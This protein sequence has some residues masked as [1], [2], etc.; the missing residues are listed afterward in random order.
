M[1]VTAWTFAKEPYKREVVRQSEPHI[2]GDKNHESQ[3][4]VTEAMWNAWDLIVNLRGLGWNWPRGLRIPSQTCHTDSVPIFLVLSLVRL[5]FYTVA[6]DVTSGA[7]RSF[8]PETFGP[9][10][11]GTIFD[12][13][14]PPV[15][16]Y[17]RASLISFLSAWTAYFV[18]EMVYQIHAIEFTL[19]FR[20]R[21]SQWPPLFDAPWMATSI[22]NF[23]GRRWH[24]LFRDCFVAVGSRP[25][26]RYLGRVGGVMGAF[27]VSGILH[28]LGLRGMGRG[29]DSLVVIGFFLM[30]GVGLALEYAWKKGTG[31]YVG[32]F[33]GWL[34]MMTWMLMWGNLMVDA[35]A[36]RGLVGSEFFPEAYRPT[37][38]LLAWF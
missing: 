6:F 32:G 27:F 29:G 34:W 17:L 13:S 33:G 4:S 15:A 28:D 16:R 31:K 21:P 7:V 19:L 5:A 10:A 18:I 38:L 35:W 37:T 11:G 23:W 8:S 2:N 9:A 22:A 20:Q 24:Q 36:R 26:K 1:R 14:L 12:P 25:L 30:N 3:V